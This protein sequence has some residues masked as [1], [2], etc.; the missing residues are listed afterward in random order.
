MPLTD[1]HDITVEPLN[2]REEARHPATYLQVELTEDV[3]RDLEAWLQ[4]HLTG[5][6]TAMQPILKRFQ[7]EVD[8]LEGNMP[9][10]DYPYAG[11]FRVNYPLTKKKVREIANRVKQAYLDSD[12]VWGI[13]LDDPNLFELAIKI[14]KAL[15]TAIDH[16]LDEEDDLSQTI[17]EATLHG[18]GV[19]A[20][21]WLYHEERVRQLETWEGFD[22]KKLE[23]LSDLLAFES[24]Y[25]SWRD[26]PELVMLHSQ[27][28]HGQRE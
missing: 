9:G 23:S 21:G 26:E 1:P 18:C 20:P 6:E 8:Q 3:R 14:E 13:D 16:E 15:D 25:P 2:D 27:L 28:R 17:F 22:G 24:K 19:L 12:P 4:L 5:I 10:S 7:Q 11:A